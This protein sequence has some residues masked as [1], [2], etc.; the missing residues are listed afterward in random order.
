MF[1]LVI[2]MINPSY[3]L[4]SKARAWSGLPSGNELKGRTVAVLR[5]LVDDR[6]ACVD[7]ERGIKS[8]SYMR[9]TWELPVK[10]QNTI[11]RLE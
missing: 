7:T 10:I 1:L 5:L 8:G 3:Y 6:E 4:G 9:G 2:F 11:K